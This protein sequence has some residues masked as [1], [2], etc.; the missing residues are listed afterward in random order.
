[1]N[2]GKKRALRSRRAKAGLAPGTLVHIGDISGVAAKSVLTA[3]NEQSLSEKPVLT[4]DIPSADDSKVVWINV[5][6]IQDVA[7]VEKIGETY[8]LHRLVLEDMVNTDSR[9]KLERF[10]D[11]LFFVVKMLH[12]PKTAQEFSVEQVSFV[13]KGNT[14]LSFQEGIEGDAFNPVRERL[15]TGHGRIRKA[16]ADFLAYSLIDAVVDNYFIVL[17]RIGERIE[18]LEETLLNNAHPDIL[19]EIHSLKREMIFIRKSV[20]PMRELVSGLTKADPFVHEETVLYLRDVY[21]HTVQMIDTIELFR[22]ILTGLLDLYL[23]MVNK[24]MNEVMKVLAV[25]STIFMPLTFIAGLYG[26]N[27]KY[28]PE[29]EWRFG[30]FMILGVMFTSVC[31]MLIVFKI[32]KWF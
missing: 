23:S 14:L 24:R 5:E 12:Y 10:D 20:W 16:G 30:Y 27:F 13:L 2:S 22:D 4:D 11:Y 6:G 28:M 8:G 31:I 1:M 17:E 19:K 9:P 25:I 18:T 15:R 32:K 21:D 29:L 7:L 26:M 3:Y